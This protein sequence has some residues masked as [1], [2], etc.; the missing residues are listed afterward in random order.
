LAT[1][2]CLFL[3]GAIVVPKIERYTQG[4]AIDFYESKRG[5]DVYVHVLGF[6]S[7]AHLF[8]FQKPISKVS[9]EKGEA[10]EDWLLN[11]KIDKP[12][13]FVTKFDRYE[14]Y[15]NHPNL[16]LIKEENGF[17]FLKRRK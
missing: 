7:Y 2:V 1:A 14:E 9:A 11:G 6:K 17:I 13:F 15:R 3:F 8:Y 5:Q 4:A 12:V 10:Y 16:E